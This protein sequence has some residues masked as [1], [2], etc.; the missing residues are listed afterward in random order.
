M[1]KLKEDVI[2]SL[3][4]AAFICVAAWFFSFF[5]WAAVVAAYEVNTTF[6]HVCL[7]LNSAIWG[8]LI[9]ERYK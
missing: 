6:G 4:V 3:E 8:F 9:Y 2:Y 5:G 7:C 1:K